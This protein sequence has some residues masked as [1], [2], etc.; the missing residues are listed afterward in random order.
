MEG[1][2]RASHIFFVHLEEGQPDNLKC[3][4]F[5][6]DII[7]YHFLYAYNVKPFLETTNTPYNIFLIYR[8]PYLPVFL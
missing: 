6:D 5:G 7:M 4:Y 8:F 1:F 3:I 2:R